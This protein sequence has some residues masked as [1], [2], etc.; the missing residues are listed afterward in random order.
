MIYSLQSCFM[1]LI[2]FYA[3]ITGEGIEP[4]NNLYQVTWLPSGE[5]KL[6]PRIDSSFQT[7]CYFLAPFCTASVGYCGVPLRTLTGS[8]NHNF[9]NTFGKKLM[10]CVLLLGNFQA[11]W[12]NTTY[13]ITYW[14][15]LKHEN[16]GFTW[17][18]SES[19]LLFSFKRRACVF[20]NFFGFFLFAACSFFAILI[21]YKG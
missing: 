14:V 8:Q 16:M 21:K 4:E 20:L 11:L 19:I 7:P 3:C 1:C 12:T 9:K 2:S 13:H 10:A 18:F 17:M 5:S 15:S 6:E